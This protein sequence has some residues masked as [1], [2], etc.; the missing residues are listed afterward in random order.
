M[1]LEGPSV[2]TFIC[3]AIILETSSAKLMMSDEDSTFF[4]K[5]S[6]SFRSSAKSRVSFFKKKKI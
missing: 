1:L 5:S 2:V 6:F 3:G 4:N